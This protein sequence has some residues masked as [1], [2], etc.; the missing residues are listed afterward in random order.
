MKLDQIPINARIR[1]TQRV[2]APGRDG[3]QPCGYAEG[4]FA[5]QFVERKSPLKNAFAHGPSN[6]YPLQRI[7]VI[8]DDGEKD[9]LV[10]DPRTSIEVVDENQPRSRCVKNPGVKNS[11]RSVSRDGIRGCW[12][13]QISPRHHAG[14]NALRVEHNCG[15]R[16]AP[17]SSQPATAS[18][19]PDQASSPDRRFDTATKPQS[20]TV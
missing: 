12:L 6:E 11:K 18:S 17:S 20:R 3:V 10:V 15:E 2:F 7:K 14:A 1:V 9:I 13:D 16:T 4:R 8:K 5:G 19:E